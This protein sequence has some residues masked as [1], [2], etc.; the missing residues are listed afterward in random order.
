MKGAFHRGH[1]AP[2]HPTVYPARI[3]E[4]IVFV[5]R[6]DRVG[7][8]VDKGLAP[9]E[10]PSGIAYNCNGCDRN[11]NPQPLFLRQSPES[12]FLIGILQIQTLRFA[13]IE[14]ILIQPVP[15]GDALGIILGWDGRF[16]TG[17]DK[18]KLVDRWLELYPADFRKVHFWPGMRIL[19]ADA[20]S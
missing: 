16:A 18:C 8:P 2:A 9:F 4:I 20:V 13:P 1:F 7:N 11:Y 17:P 14:R 12:R 5:N 6:L 19:P 15:I 3:L 10:L